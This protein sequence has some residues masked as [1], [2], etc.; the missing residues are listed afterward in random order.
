MFLQ[1]KALHAAHRRI[2]ATVGGLRICGA[3]STGCPPQDA[4]VVVLV[5]GLGT[6]SRAVLPTLGAL[7]TDFRVYAVDLPGYGRSQTPPHRLNLPGLADALAGWIRALGV[8]RAVVVGHSLG[9]QVLAHLATRHPALVTAVVLV[10]PSCDPSKGGRFRLAWQLLRDV[11]RE[12]PAWPLVAVVDYARARPRRVWA[13]LNEALHVDEEQRLQE[14]ELPALIVRGQR[15]PVVGQWWVERITRVLPDARL[16][17]VPR[18]G[19]AI[20]YSRPQAVARHVRAFLAAQ[21]PGAA[22]E[23]AGHGNS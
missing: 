8:D 7:A 17:V 18:A 12:V 10:S 22:A 2:E 16:V 3:V 1:G 9:C 19:H 23:D 15:D 21:A 4:P 20:T 13:L 14:I 11:P 5:H 6:S